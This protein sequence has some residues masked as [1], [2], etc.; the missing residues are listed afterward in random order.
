MTADQATHQGDGH[1]D[2]RASIRH[3]VALSRTALF[4]AENGLHLKGALWLQFA[5]SHKKS[6]AGFHNWGYP[7]MDGL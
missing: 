5:A 4:A 2:L 6:C 7:Q 3:E 1:L